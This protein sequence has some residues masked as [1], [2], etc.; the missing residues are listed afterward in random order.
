MQQDN[1]E[2]LSGEVKEIL[3]SPPSWVTTWGIAFLVGTVGLIA[4]AGGIFH[5]PEIVTGN[6]SITTQ[7]PPVM[8]VSPKSEYI[9]EVKVKDNMVVK[10]GDVLAIF[11][12]D[13]DYRDVLKLE[14]D[15]E[16]VG[17][18][19]LEK[20]RSYTPNQSLN[21]GELRQAYS[22]FITAF[23]LVP[24]DETGEIDYA[25]VAAVENTS[26]QYKQEV[27][28]LESSLPSIKTE[29]EAL[30]TELKNAHHMYAKTTDTTYAA[31]I[32]NVNSRIKNKEAE[33]KRIQNSIEATKTE[34][35]KSNIRKLQA[36]T[37]AKSGAGEAIFHLNKRLDDLKTEIKNWKNNYLL[38]APS[39]GIVQ[40][41][42][43]IKAPQFV[44]VGDALF[45]ILP[46]DTGTKFVGKVELPVDRSG[47]VKEGQQVN[48]KFDRYRF[49]EFGTVKAKVTKVYPVAKDNAFYADI[50]IENGLVTTLNRKL[51]FLSTNER[52]GRNRHG[53]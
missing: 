50:F 11:P 43:P 14:A 6:V 37:Q 2:Y 35:S 5:Y 18:L 9:S 32:F 41:Y 33:Y 36:Q 26:L 1:I 40:I 10:S 12:S 53:R 4:F 47:K 39:N 28:S 3:S 38:L 31:I 30:N 42:M 17:Q 29:L 48:I 44:S 20:L 22:N 21:I 27:K 34:I 46:E 51:D 7:T 25:T 23:E 45:S 15:I 52:Q 24:L 19:D 16:T 49:R 13:A 8:I